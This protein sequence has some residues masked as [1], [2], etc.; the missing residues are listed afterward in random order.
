MSENT[1]RAFKAFSDQQYAN[2][3]KAAVINLRETV[4]GAKKAGLD[5]KLEADSS[6]CTSGARV[7]RNFYPANI[8]E[9]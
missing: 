4:R 2:A 5:V 9:D 8:D 1:E 6:G 7:S 3:I